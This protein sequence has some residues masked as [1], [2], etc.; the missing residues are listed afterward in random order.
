MFQ[1]GRHKLKDTDE[2]LSSLAHSRSVLITPIENQEGVRLAKKVFLVQLVGTQLHGCNI[3]QEKTMSLMKA[4]G[5]VENLSLTVKTVFNVQCSM[6]MQTGIRIVSTV[7]QNGLITDADYTDCNLEFH[8]HD[9]LY[10]WEN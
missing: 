10:K 8:L 7:S 5:F 2:L 1:V 3:L 6:A 4:Q 9:R